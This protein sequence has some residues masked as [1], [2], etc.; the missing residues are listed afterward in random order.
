MNKRKAP[1]DD[2]DA[3]VE[4][5]PAEFEECELTDSDVDDADDAE[6]DQ[7]A[8]E[9]AIDEDDL[10]QSPMPPLRLPS[11]AYRRSDWIVSL[12]ALTLE[13]TAAAVDVGVS[14]P[15]TLQIEYVVFPDSQ[16]SF[17][18]VER[19]QTRVSELR[20]KIVEVR[21]SVRDLVRCLTGGDVG[22]VGGVGGVGDDDRRRRRTT[23]RASTHPPRALRTWVECEREYPQI[24]LEL[25]ELQRQRDVLSEM[26]WTMGARTR[27]NDTRRALGFVVSQLDAY[28]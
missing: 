8:I 16:S 21:A 5:Y 6:A 27:D 28:L 7:A 12:S 10:T 22:G 3:D 18:T 25:G 14:A 9:A 15:R 23:S 11:P 17:W 19:M 4:H 2:D 24:R 1:A 13:V 20:D 26:C